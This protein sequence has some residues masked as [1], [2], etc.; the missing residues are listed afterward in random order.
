[1]SVRIYVVDDEASSLDA[2]RDLLVEALGSAKISHV[3]RAFTDG[4]A[5]LAAA[6]EESPHI[7]VTDLLMPRFDGFRVCKGLRSMSSGAEIEL[8]A[9]SG[10]YRTNAV[11]EKVNRDYQAAFFAKPAE[12][13]ELCKAVLD[14]AT[15]LQAVAQRAGGATKPSPSAVLHAMQPATMVGRATPEM[16]SAAAAA[17][18]T[19]GGAGGAGAGTIIGISPS[20]VPAGNA[21]AAMG[22]ALGGGAGDLSDRGLPSLLLD[23]A[24]RRQTGRLSL[25]RGAQVKGIDLSAGQ[26]VAIHSSS[27]EETLGQFL[28][29]RG[30]IS[31]AQYKQ[32]LA[33]IAKSQRRA[34]EVLIALGILGVEQISDHLL[35]QL[36]FKLAQVIRWPQAQ[37][38]FDASAAID[39]GDGMRLAVSGAVLRALRDTASGVLE[40]MSQKANVACDVNPRGRGLLSEIGGTF[41]FALSDALAKP[42]VIGDILA[43][44]GEAGAQ[45]ID[46]LVLVDGLN[47]AQPL[48]LAALR[49][50]SANSSR[51]RAHSDPPK[52]V[53]ARASTN[54]GA[55]EPGSGPGAAAGGSNGGAANAVRRAATAD[56]SGDAR[57]TSLGFGVVGGG[58]PK[59]PSE[60]SGAGGGN[61]VLR[62][63]SAPLAV[64]TGAAS[65]QELDQGWDEN[66]TTVNVRLG[67]EE[68]GVLHTEATGKRSPLADE[69]MRRELHEEV[70]RVAGLDYF[71]ALELPFG[72]THDQLVDALAI[73]RRQFARARYRAVPL[74]ADQ[75]KLEALTRLY[76]KIEQVLLDPKAREQYL[77]QLGQSTFSTEK[78]SVVAE[79]VYRD[80][81]ALIGQRQWPGAIEKLSEAV[82]LA[83]IEADYHAELG[84]AYFQAGG[85]SSAAAALARPHLEQALSI[86]PDHA[87]A[88]AW[89]GRTLQVIGGDLLVAIFHFE[90]SLTIAPAFHPAATWLAQAIVNQFD[91]GS[92]ALRLTA[93]AGQLS[94]PAPAS[95]AEVWTA[96]GAWQ[97]DVVSDAEGARGS[98]NAALALVPDHGVAQAR[99]AQLERDGGAGFTATWREACDA[100]AEQG[101]GAAHAKRLVAIAATHDQH[102]AT[103][104]AAAAAAVVG[105]HDADI[106]A[107]LQ[108]LRPKY[109]IRANAELSDAYVRRIAHLDD[110]PQLGELM[111]R[112]APVVA[113]LAPLAPEDIGIEDGQIPDQ[114]L[115]ANLLRVRDYVAG[116]MGAPAL[117]IYV[118]PSLG[119]EVIMAALPQPS[120]VVG[121]LANGDQVDRYE[122]VFR[123][124][125]ALSFRGAGRLVG[126]SRTGR[127]L[128]EAI[129]A[130]LLVAE[131]TMIGELGV[132]G[133]RADHLAFAMQALPAAERQE[134]GL[135]ALRCVA[136]HATLNMTAWSRALTATANRIGVMAC[137][138]LDA[139]RRVVPAGD[140]PDLLRFWLSPDHMG[141]RAEL[142]LSID[143]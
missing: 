142:G 69:Q 68:S 141:L 39:D 130:A 38:R 143:V 90:R 121:T 87:R 2:L 79:Q 136:G 81:I 85:E 109:I 6:A 114:G 9:I 64:T 66:Q 120:L 16:I 88:H 42:F 138:D 55:G 96:L 77:A 78:P 95:A 1:M 46:A 63:V 17:A 140:L 50:L 56:G 83:P 82:A 18:R 22:A 103:F 15:R 23:L 137:G 86:A 61:K 105:N 124:A 62:P 125:R 25:R 98:L 126:G 111:N 43:K 13:R 51:T 118:V 65:G 113:A 75:S 99:L 89:L 54:G 30:V 107:A 101:F 93:L 102:D 110:D 14:A 71:H 134:A 104:L 60:P 45:A 119:H 139:A 34:G 57:K 117:P 48:E 108:R 58:G 52:L 26:I 80:A 28:L 112:L 32:T 92:I 3:L 128:R 74:G 41:G 106:H 21:S 132:S 8:F 133:D 11:R 84:H 76:E 47:V 20:G 116:W 24:E 49:S 131:P 7:V 127:V 19:G 67:N 33:E 37:W 73:K 10:I 97:L 59:G 40:R 129:I 44:R 115:S 94:Q 100:W 35:R 36:H 91:R 123:F 72:A 53:N 12:L 122:L 135:L 70:R 27:R 29:D 5:A 4:E 31:E